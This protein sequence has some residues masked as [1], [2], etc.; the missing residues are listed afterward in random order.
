MTFDHYI[1]LDWAQSNMAIARM[2]AKSDRAEVKDIPSD[3]AEMKVYLRNLKGRKIL[4]IEESTTAQWLYTELR[5]EV[6]EILICDPRRNHLL[7]EGPK[8]DKID[9]EKLVRL[10]RAGML[11]PVFHTADQFVWLRKL[12]S[13]YQDC[14]K[15]GVR[16][17][18]Q[19]SSLF[20]ANGLSNKGGKLDNPAEAFVLQGLDKGIE[21]YE[22]DK[23]RYEKEFEVWRKKHRIIR[24]LETIPGIGTIGAVKIAAAIVDARRFAERNAFI[25]YCGLIKL[26]RISGGRSYGKKSPQYN[27]TLKSVFKTAALA[28]MDADA[29][30]PLKEYYD[31]LIFQ[32]RYPDHNARHALARR[33]ATLAWG[34]M[35]SGKQ[36]DRERLKTAAR[37]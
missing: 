27:R 30:S 32:K 16:L 13:G 34:V 24:H 29:K 10:L 22:A 9:A 12:A 14:V 25:S 37:T 36:F 17:K 15:A 11:K 3:I 1:G 33:I 4:T 35:K 23:K 20:R 21:D 28:C 2:T 5:A 7:S 6:D 8:T 18:N 19:R 26:E 31:Y